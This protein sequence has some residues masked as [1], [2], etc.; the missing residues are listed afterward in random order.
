[1]N[2]GSATAYP[3]AVLDVDDMDGHGPETVSVHKPVSGTFHIWAECYSCWGKSSFKKFK[4]N[5][6][7]VK[8]FDRYG[9][10]YNGNI[11]KAKGK[12]SKYWE[13]AKRKCTGPKGK[14]KERGVVDW[15]D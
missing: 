8:I 1:M 12:P 10:T 14:R 9:M 11:A 5:G 13:V 7:H 2:R 3:Y 15:E 4:N 6:A